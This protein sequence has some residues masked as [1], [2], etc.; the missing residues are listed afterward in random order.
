MKIGDKVQRRPVT[1]G[2]LEGENG[3]RQAFTG[4][5]VYIHPKGRYHMVGFTV[6]SGRIRE[7]FLGS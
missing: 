2:S 3:L 6:R 7:C 1:F 4:R 5:V